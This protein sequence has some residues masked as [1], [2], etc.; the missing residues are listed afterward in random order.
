MSPTLQEPLQSQALTAAAEVSAL[1]WLHRDRAWHGL[2]LTKSSKQQAPFPSEVADSFLLSVRQHFQTGQ[3]SYLAYKPHKRKLD[4]ES[5]LRVPHLTKSRHSW[6]N[7]SSHSPSSS[8][9]ISQSYS[10]FLDAGSIT[11][12]FQ[13][14]AFQQR[15]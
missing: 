2:T 7:Q 4:A 10:S 1:M 9:P 3:G 12:T 14:P 8:L 11:L 6:I 13:K 15:I 5:Q